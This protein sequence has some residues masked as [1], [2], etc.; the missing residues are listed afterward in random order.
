MHS[1]GVHFSFLV[2][3]VGR[4]GL[5][6]TCRHHLAGLHARADVPTALSLPT[7]LYEM[8]IVT[9]KYPV[10]SIQSLVDAGQ[11]YRVQ[12]RPCQGLRQLSQPDARY[13]NLWPVADDH[14][15][16]ATGCKFQ[17]CRQ[18]REVRPT[19]HHRQLH[20]QLRAVVAKLQQL[21][22][23]CIRRHDAKMQH[24]WLHLQ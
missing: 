18:G 24:I 17:L 22:S 13:D 21:V 23:P 14:L 2:G 1:A 9:H 10:R 15:P 3:W 12:T 20:G 11:L 5:I 8:Q 7:W 4:E 6:S 16:S 19:R